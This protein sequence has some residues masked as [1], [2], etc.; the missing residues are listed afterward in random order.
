[1][2][3][4][5]P[6]NDTQPGAEYEDQFVWDANAE[7]PIEEPTEDSSLFN[8]TEQRGKRKADESGPKESKASKTE[9]DLITQEE[10][11]PAKSVQEIIKER[12][13]NALDTTT[14]LQTA[15]CIKW[16]LPKGCPSFSIRQA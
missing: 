16:V 2:S 9:V 4:E 14:G 7:E 8:D 5:A 13:D 15:V 12:G 1:M 3:E 6:A 10:K 11:K